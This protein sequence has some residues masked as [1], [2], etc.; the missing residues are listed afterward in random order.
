MNPLQQTVQPHNRFRPEHPSRGR[1][2]D[3]TVREGKPAPARPGPDE[4]F[5]LPPEQLKEF[6]RLATRHR[7][8]LAALMRAARIPT[9]THLNQ[10][11]EI[12]RHSASL[13]LQHLW[14]VTDDDLI[15]LSSI[16]VPRGT[17]RLVAFAI[18]GAPNLGTA[19]RRYQEFRAAFPGL[20]DIT[21]EASQGAAALSI[22]HAAFGASSISAVTVG[23]LAVAHRVINWAT[24]R[25][26]LLHRVELPHARPTRHGG[27]RL[28]FGAPALFAAP[29][30]ALVFN[31]DFLTQPFV[32]SHQDIERFLDDPPAHLLGE[33]DFYCS[34]VADQVRRII[35]DRLGN[36]S[37][38]SD[39]IAAGV[40]MSR[41]T[42][43]R[44]LREENTSISQIRDQV[45]RDAAL[46]AL[47]CGNQTVAQL[48]QH[49]GFSE[50]SAFSRAF[51]RWTGSSPRNYQVSRHQT[52]IGAPLARRLGPADPE[53]PSGSMVAA[54]SDSR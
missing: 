14:R 24:R 44:R 43:W 30:A 28:V 22:D 5:N 39:D 40:G 34:T 3:P 23:L 1:C 45:L 18:C 29:R 7:W 10:C 15:G 54:H 36:P 32:R 26:L 8:D 25:P 41:P 6:A 17:L 2:L 49:L 33:C 31:A 42:L 52:D 16:Q 37:C 50:P 11:V 19:L 13:G 48:S 38:T 53:Q 9:P 51:R 46:A 4:G 12:T 35:E 27:Y 47:S 20:P 21:I